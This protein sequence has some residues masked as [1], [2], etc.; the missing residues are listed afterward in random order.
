MEPTDIPGVLSSGL[1]DSDKMRPMARRFSIK[2][3]EYIVEQF[4]SELT[5]PYLNH[6]I[7]FLIQ[8]CKDSEIHVQNSAVSTTGQISQYFLVEEAFQINP[9]VMNIFM[10]PLIQFSKK[11]SNPSIQISGIAAISSAID[12]ISMNMVIMNLNKLMSNLV[13]IMMNPSTAESC[14]AV[15]IDALRKIV[16]LVW[17]FLQETPFGS[18]PRM[19]GIGTEVN[20]TNND[21]LVPPITW[22]YICG[23]FGGILKELHPNHTA[24]SKNV[25]VRC[26]SLS[27]LTELMVCCFVAQAGALLAAHNSNIPLQKPVDGIKSYADTI[28]N[29]INLGSKD[30]SPKVREVAQYC[31][32]RLQEA[33]EAY[34]PDSQDLV[35]FCYNSTLVNQDKEQQNDLNFSKTSRQRRTLNEDFFKNATDEIIVRHVSPPPNLKF[36]DHK[37]SVTCDLTND[38]GMGE[39][40]YQENDIQVEEE[41]KEGGMNAHEEGHVKSLL[42]NIENNED[43][44]NGEKECSQGTVLEAQSLNEG[45]SNTSN[46]VGCANHIY[47]HSTRGFRL[48]GDN[49]FLLNDDPTCTVGSSRCNTSLHSPLYIL[50]QQQ[51]VIQGQMITA[52][53]GLS[54]VQTTHKQTEQI[55]RQTILEKKIEELTLEVKR[56]YSRQKELENV[57][58]VL[59][60]VAIHRVDSLEE[61]IEKL[62]S[63]LNVV[64]AKEVSQNFKSAPEETQ[65]IKSN[66][67]EQTLS[68]FRRQIYNKAREIVSENVN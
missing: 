56:L 62:S 43:Y 6:I 16:V 48:A 29:A 59:K 23:T 31:M 47:A 57:A 26:A 30:K 51:P 28:M 46:C 55:E 34:I 44:S 25:N 41:K 53:P 66:N 42:T 36:N 19:Y 38:D 21:T 68:N 63:S 5:L 50:A 52:Y 32:K 18:S 61:K 65:N 15:V 22:K 8:G 2:I 12:G 35:N 54:Q 14:R 1:L 24:N 37:E 17:T 11:E 4:G 10:D 13:P 45:T 33:N 27:L 39:K 40:C 49:P 7:N 3:V 20:F 64:V 67:Q 9:D 60:I 58:H